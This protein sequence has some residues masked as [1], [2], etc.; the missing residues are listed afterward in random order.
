MESP[1]IK[2]CKLNEQDVCIGCGRTKDEI[3]GW[4][5]MTDAERT[6]A[7]KKAIGKV[8]SKTPS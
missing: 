5:S 2:I 3:S 8:L 7:I 1:C 6:E 4:T